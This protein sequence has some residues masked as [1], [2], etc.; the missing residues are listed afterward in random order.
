MRAWEVTMQKL[1]KQKI[2]LIHE[3]APAVWIGGACIILCA[4]AF[5]LTAMTGAPSSIDFASMAVLP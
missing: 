5:F 2:P 1:P 3:D 4:L